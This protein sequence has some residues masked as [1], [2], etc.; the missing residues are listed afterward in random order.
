MHVKRNDLNAKSRMKG[1]F[2]VRFRERLRVKFPWSTRQNEVWVG[3]YI[4]EDLNDDGVID[5]KDRTYLGNP[6]P[7]FSYGF[8]NSFSYKG[9]DLNIFIN[10]VYGNK[11]V[12]LLR[13]EFTNPMNNSGMLKEATNIARVELIDP[14]QP[15]TLS[16]VHVVNAGSA[17]VQRI[18][19]SDAND[20]NRMSSRFVEDGSY[21]RI[22]N[23]SLGYTF[24]K[25]WI[26]KFNIDNLRV[27]MNIQ[28]AFTFTK[29]KG[30][31]VKTCVFVCYFLL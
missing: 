4:F 27:Y 25:K 22:K 9:F 12:N 21:L 20:N 31:R 19:A 29:Y 18:T 26:S 10:G 6:D 3:D 16:N 28:N 14:T 8:N 11:V 5:E 13:K 15:A 17:E 2:H 23:I 24:P 30:A 1:D 7:K